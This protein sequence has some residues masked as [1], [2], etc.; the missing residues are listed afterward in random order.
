MFS[1]VSPNIGMQGASPTYDGL[2]AGTATHPI[3]VGAVHI[4]RHPEVPNFHQ[5]VLSHQAVPGGQ[6]TVHKVLGRQVDH[7]CCDLLSDV[8]H[9][10]LRQ[11]SGRVTFCHQHRIWPVCPAGEHKG[12]EPQLEDWRD[13]GIPDPSIFGSLPLLQAV[14]H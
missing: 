4:P 13:V 12:L 8:Q 10:R 6:V 1:Y 5:Q 3:V 11:L 9:L 2:L 7:A 14:A